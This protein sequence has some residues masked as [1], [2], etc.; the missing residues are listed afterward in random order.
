MEKNKVH[1]HLTVPPDNLMEVN[2][3]VIPLS[4]ICP[5]FPY[6]DINVGIKEAA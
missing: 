4:N 1:T 6:E 5:W 3:H 2:S